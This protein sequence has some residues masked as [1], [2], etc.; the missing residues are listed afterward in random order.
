MRWQKAL[1]LAGVA[2][3]Y[4]ADGAY[5][6]ASAETMNS[7]LAAAYKNNPTIRA[8][9]AAVRA[10]DEGVPQALSGWRPTITASG[11]YGK[12]RSQDV[13]RD[14]TTV[15]G[16][17]IPG[18][19]ETV[20]TKP[21]GA[22]VTLTQPLFRGGRTVNSTR[23]AD[24]TVFAAR[25]N[26]ISVEQSVLLETATAFL[27]V[28]RDT[29]IVNLRVKNVAVLREQ[30]RASNARFRVGEI[31][32]TDVAQ[33]R[34]RLSGSVSNL[35]SAKATLA[36]SRAEYA[37]VVGRAPGSL[38]H[39]ASITRLLPRSLNAAIQIARDRN[40]TLLAAAFNEKA[41]Y[42]AID[43]VKGELLP[44]IS[45]EA[46]YNRR[47][48]NSAI[49]KSTED[50]SI[51]GRIDIPLYQSGSVYS[52]VR[53][54]KQTNSQR[55]LQIAEADRQVHAEV[56]S[57]WEALRASRQTIQSSRVQVQAN[58]LALK[59]VRQEARVG[60]RTTLDVLDAEEELLNSRVSLVTARRDMYVAGYRLLS[61]IGRLTARDLRL[62]VAYYDPAKHHNKVRG[63]WIGFGK[64]ESE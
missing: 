7:A 52:R 17:A 3:I 39:K 35:S 34:A 62:P 22:N 2:L 43:V 46:R 50:A 24:A 53:A 10:T 30:L 29:A 12:N 14:A 21:G 49:S 23:E 26:L 57:A 38:R 42:H 16:G 54:A 27:N 28:V 15:G 4:A 9:R 6:T 25:Q 13:T 1:A 18:G 63:K 60:S 56:V 8:Q 44:T 51:I 41:S 61:A 45:L 19:R 37:R 31:T 59:G 36:A 20:Y 58:D 32:R 64:R 55:R 11:D 40:P 5:Q 47:H 48:D 33:S